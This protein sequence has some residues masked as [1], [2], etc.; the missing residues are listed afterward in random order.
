MNNDYS[1]FIKYLDSLN[2]NK[3]K[4]HS[5]IDAFNKKSINVDNNAQLIKLQR[6]KDISGIANTKARDIL[7]IANAKEKTK[8]KDVLGIV[9]AKEKTKAKAKDVLGIANAKE[10]T[11]AKDV[12]GIV[13]IKEKAK[14]KA[15]AKDVLDIVNIKEK[16]KAKAKAKDVLDIVNIKEKK[17]KDVLG[18]ANAK[19][20]GKDVSGIANAKVKGKDV[21]GIAKAKEKAKDVSGIANAKEKAKDI[22]AIANTKVISGL[23]SIYSIFNHNEK[24]GD[25]GGGGGVDGGGG[26]GGGVDGGGVDGDGGGGGGDG[27]GGGSID[28]GYDEKLRLLEKEFNEQFMLGLTGIKHIN[29]DNINDSHETN[30]LNS[31]E[32]RK[33][34]EDLFNK[35]MAGQLSEPTYKT[36]VF[37]DDTFNKKKGVEPITIV[38]KSLKEIDALKYESKR[39]DKMCIEPALDGFSKN[40]LCI[41]DMDKFL[42]N[43]KT[44]IPHNIKY[45]T[46]IIYK[47]QNTWYLLTKKSVGILEYKHIK[48]LK[49]CLKQFIEGDKF[50]KVIN[51][52]TYRCCYLL[53]NL[54]KVVTNEIELVICTKIN[55]NDCTNNNDP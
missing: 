37:N 11:K 15:K 40:K 7:D 21:S 2:F 27:G 35:K 30:S 54:D 53:Y 41:I 45:K 55:N 51:N 28:I 16:T 49:I 20:K 42:E 3:K 18:I 1:S 31:I 13:N 44:Y 6:G 4:I 12:L 32:K 5:V 14:A 43:F 17:A 9:N 22:L 19:V 23:K 29:L 34:L 33:E 26:D 36:D 48:F 38:K 10:K 52:S 50:K 46:F 24:T 8:A 39:F 25:D 47:N